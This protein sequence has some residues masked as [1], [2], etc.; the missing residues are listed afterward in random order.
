MCVKTA[1]VIIT[2]LVSLACLSPAAEAKPIKVTSENFEF[3]GDTSEKSAIS[4]VESL[5]AYRAILFS[6]Y[7]IDPGPE[8]IPVKIYGFK[9]QSRI[10]ALTGMSNI[11]GLYTTT[12]EGPVFLLTTEGGF[13]KGKAA[14]RI[15]YHEYTHHVLSSVASKTYPVWYNEGF[16]D[17]VSTFEYNP[18]NREYKIGL[19]SN[20]N[21]WSLS[22]NEWIPYAG[23]TQSVLKYPFKSSGSKANSRL[24]AL[25]Y[26]QSWL[27]AHYIQSSPSYS[28]KLNDYIKVINTP[29]A[30]DNA[31]ET[32][33]GISLEDFEKELKAYHKANRYGY[34]KAILDDGIDIPKAT[35]EK[36]TKAELKYR[37]GEA[38][39][40]MINTKKGRALA[41]IYFDEAEEKLGK[42]AQILS[43]RA[44]LA[45]QNNKLEE[46]LTFAKS[47]YEKDPNSRHVQRILGMIELDNYLKLGAQSGSLDKARKHLMFA[48]RAYPDDA[49][50]HYYFALS[51]SNGYDTPSKQAVASAQSALEYYKDLN[52]L[53]TNL[54]LARILAKGGKKQ[55]ALPVYERVLVWAQDH[56]LRSFAEN[57]IKYLSE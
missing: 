27:A 20:N 34:A 52:F 57:E 41:K 11:G 49:T 10:E 31:F 40:Q 24:Q 12:I 36:M 51:F 46:A 38:M 21:A 54:E 17:Y 32:A 13:K 37:Y 9:T 39:R 47:A 55:L 4:L 5:E 18:K 44:M 2:V 26:A 50:A 1:S 7:K 43:S 28:A 14:S 22:A 19:P 16:A 42:T 23:I 35:A 6:L 33:M 53:H 30:P 29:D 15:A 25:F 8:Y 48:L 56:S 3:Y 45:Y